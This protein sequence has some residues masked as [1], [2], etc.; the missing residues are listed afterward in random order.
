VSHH[1]ELF[2]RLNGDT[3]GKPTPVEI[4]RGGQVQTVN[5]VVGER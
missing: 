3:V 4:L 2:T 1:D 5:V